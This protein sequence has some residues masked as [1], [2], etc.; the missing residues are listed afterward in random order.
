MHKISSTDTLEG[1]ALHYHVSKTAL[2]ALNNLV[3]D[4][5]FFLKEIKIPHQ[6]KTGIYLVL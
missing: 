6:S 2:K 4:D 3:S 5:I 1:L